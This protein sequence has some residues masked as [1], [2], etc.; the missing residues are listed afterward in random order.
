MPFVQFTADNVDHDLR[1]L[2][3]LEMI[4]GM[5]IMEAITPKTKV[6]SKDLP[7][8]SVDFHEL[9]TKVGNIAVL[10]QL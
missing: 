3:G 9:I 8:I 10:L 4:H 6:P 7:R 5:G 1:T 2:N